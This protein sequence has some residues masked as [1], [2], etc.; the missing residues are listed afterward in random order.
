MRAI[1]G[2]RLLIV[3]ESVVVS[4]L[5]SGCGGGGG[6]G[7]SG[8]ARPF[9]NGDTQAINGLTGGGGAAFNAAG[10]GLAVWVTDSG[11]DFG[12]SKV[13]CAH[14]SASQ[15]RWSAELEIGVFG[16]YPRVAASATDFMVAWR[17]YDPGKMYT[18]NLYHGI[19]V[20]SYSGTT[21]GPEVEL[22]SDASIVS[23]EGAA[24]EMVSDGLGHA[25]IWLQRSG[26]VVDV[27]GSTYAGGSWSAPQVLDSGSTDARDPVLASSGPGSYAVAWVQSDGVADSIYASVY[28]GGGWTQTLL[29][30]AAGV[31]GSPRIAA[32][33][34]GYAVVWDQFDGA[35]T[36]IY[37]NIYNGSSWQN[38]LPALTPLEARPGNA[39]NPRVASNGA[40]Y[41]VVWVQFDG[42][43]FDNIF[44]NVFNGLI[45]TGEQYL[46]MADG[47]AHSPEIASNGS[48]YAATWLQEDGEDSP[49]ASVYSSGAWSAS[50]APL[51]STGGEAHDPEICRNGSNYA[52]SWIQ[53]DVATISLYG[54]VHGGSG[55]SGT[56]LLEHST[57]PVYGGAVLPRGTIGCTAAWMQWDGERF[58][59]F[60]SQYEN[61]HWS[62]EWALVR[63]SHRAACEEPRLV[64]NDAGTIVAV[65]RQS[66]PTAANPLALSAFASVFRSGRWDTPLLLAEQ[67]DATPAIATDGTSFMVVWS[68]DGGGGARRLHARIFNGSAWGGDMAL[69]SVPDDAR[70]PRVAS[71]GSSYGVVWDQE[72]PS[73]IHSVYA[74]L[75][76]AGSWST[77]EAI[78][79]SAQ[80]AYDMVIASH[81][82]GYAAA[83]SQSDGTKDRIFANNYNGSWIPAAATALATTGDN[84]WDP[85]IASDGSGY[86]VTWAHD[87]GA[88]HI[89]I[90]AN[91]YSPVEGVWNP[92]NTL[93][94][95]ALDGDAGFARI[96][97]SG[98]GYAIVWVQEEGPDMKIFASVHDG[99]WSAP[100]NLDSSAAQAMYPMIASDGASYAVV[101]LTLDVTSTHTYYARFDAGAW[102]A[103]RALGDPLQNTLLPD[104]AAVPGVGYGAVYMQRDTT[105]LTVWNIFP[106]LGF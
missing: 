14:Y 54:A 63:G 17:S 28:G 48:G 89:N 35:Y 55:W 21:W 4:A 42:T 41:A 7:G 49:Y 77:P 6:G 69:P 50:P 33:N 25:L 23:F 96:A 79:S 60:A 70:M 62:A 67:F 71:N 93:L 95:D 1:S 46:E 45:W 91:I 3:V 13:L 61:N 12:W 15:R 30:A 87:D 97:S 99:A 73:S 38:P 75:Y 26:S 47:D 81:G 76:Q 31:V 66:R 53:E 32:S 104:V 78:E 101:W 59:V 92:A 106:A 105:D 57:H 16:E 10:D 44:A 100:V 98:T 52:V 39:N 65:W 36:S 84:S 85:Q 102:G 27:W 88:G 82:T 11:S 37:A 2:S 51:R 19:S 72:E 86:A 9:I 68:Q 24:I 18:G 34:L 5:L 56:A 83:W 22:V 64:A 8:H 74:S 40:G 43:F 94:V 58:N 20:R 90:Q 29:E 80:S 103:E